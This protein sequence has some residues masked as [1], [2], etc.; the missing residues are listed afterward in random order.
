MR[1]EGRPAGATLVS[2]KLLFWTAEPSIGKL[3]LWRSLIAFLTMR[4][5]RSFSLTL[6]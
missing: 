1:R 6:V 2:T 4:R 5:D 3:M